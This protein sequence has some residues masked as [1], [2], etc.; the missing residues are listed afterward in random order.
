MATVDPQKFVMTSTGYSSDILQQG[1]SRY[2]DLVF[3]RDSP[4][5]RS[6][7]LVKHVDNVIDS[8]SSLFE[9]WKKN[10]H[11]QQ[12]S[13]DSL[14]INVKTNNIELSMST[15]ESYELDLLFPNATLTANTAF[16]ALRGLETFSQ[17]V[18]YSEKSN[19]YFVVETSVVDIPRYG[20]R[21][22][23]IDTSRHYLPVNLIFA[24]IDAMVYNK[25]N[26]LI[27]HMTDDQSFPFVSQRYPLLSA[28][29]AYSK[30]LIY[31]HNDV[32]R[33][34]EYGRVRGVQIIPEF[35][36]PAHCNA[37]G[38]GYPSFLTCG[39]TQG[40]GLPHVAL[41]ST[42]D[43]LFNLFTEVSELFNNEFI[44]IG[45]DEVI[46]DCWKNNS[47]ITK[48]MESLGFG[49]DY[50]QLMSYYETQL[51]DFV[52]NKLQKRVF[53]WQDIVWWLIQTNQTLPNN[54][55]ADVWQSNGWEQ[56]MSDY[57]PRQQHL[58]LSGCFYLDSLVT[59]WTVFYQCEPTAY[60]NSSPELNKYIL[61]GHAAKWG[62][63]TDAT[64]FMPVVYPRASAIAERLW[65]PQ[66][67]NNIN[68]ARVRLIEHRCR[69][70]RRGIP[71]SP[72]TIGYC[73][74]EF[75]YPPP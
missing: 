70:V 72:I 73:P 6:L 15:D 38:K 65:S 34:I 71:A 53:V 45:G 59:D 74:Y 42:F 10:H 47:A 40:R 2:W 58:V 69:L 33:I 4:H 37:W 55:V 63:L 60:P 67:T 61:G 44:H 48:L 41:N 57:L 66:S 32:Q 28:K 23:L 13:L 64:N 43:L 52:T 68:E 3:W 18:T 7:Q 26:V 9:K 46:V 29:G 8:S 36:T 1:I 50:N 5:F 49:T 21:G 24:H 27:W 35:D 25:L 54:S 31:T 75:P 16:G 19:S 51:I 56:V 11:Q 12:L 62:E 20:F 30:N 14:L 22:T 17:L 39:E